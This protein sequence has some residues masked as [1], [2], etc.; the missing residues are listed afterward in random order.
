[1]AKPGIAP[2]ESTVTTACPLDCPDAC[3]VDVTLR[4]GR[5]AKMDG[6]KEN[7]IT[8]GYICA[9]VRRFP[10][11][12]Y[13]DDR[14]LYPAI[15]RGAKGQGQFKRV[16]WD[17]ALDL[18]A[19]K[20]IAAR[21]G[22]GAETILP[23]CYGGSNGFLTQ[24]YA[25]AILFR[26]F[27]T[28]RLLRTV[29]AAPTG[30]ANL[31]LYGKMTSVSY[32]DY[33]DAKMIIV[34]GVNPSVTGIHLMPYLKDAREKGAFIVAIDPRATTVARQADVHLAVRPGTDLA[35]ALAIHR[36][37]FEEGHAAQAFLD[38]H[39]HGAHQLRE[40][41]RPWTF[42]RAAEVSGVDASMLRQIAERYVKTSPALVKCGWGLERNRNGGSA[43]AAILALPA[44]AGKFGVRG[45][46]YTMSNSAAWNIER[47]WAAD[48][49]PP[50]R[51][52]NMNKVGRILTEPEG[53]PVNVLFVY[54]C[55]PV[56]ILPDQRRVIRGLER[57]DLFTVVFDQVLTDTAMYADVA[58]PATTFLEHYDFARGYGPIT[59]QLGKPVIDAVGESRSN[60]DVFMDLARR[61]DLTIDGDPEDDLEAMLT[62]LSHLP[63][64]V[65]DDLRDTWKARAP[66][67]GRPIQFVDVF[68]KTADQKVDLFPEV[69]DKQAPMGLYGFQP[70]PATA[71]YPLAMISPS[72]ERTIS[73]TLGELSRPDVRL[74]MN[75][76]DADARGIEDGDAIVIFNAQG[77]VRVNA[78]VSPLIKRGTVAMPKGVW[79]RNT[80]NG[81]TSNALTPD[82]LADLGGGACFN[83]ARVDVRKTE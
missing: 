42:E 24:D 82:T 64:Q 23:L 61:L 18:I 79:R 27:G 29:C 62:V 65:G 68:P 35:V 73:S 76:D 46:G 60:T 36:Y 2:T 69:L 14:L 10:E 77:E 45:G 38:E 30:A 28:S 3:T 5:I 50:T 7:H 13:G 83:D 6:S 1:M 72:S 74:E 67:G 43:A 12:V 39:T 15:R 66:H 40:K 19:E 31:G 21:D 70:D 48:P 80:A 17:D 58:L 44:V 52:V 59:L 49:E 63:Q 33:P 55:N 54:N 32:E 4:G 71:E 26:R 11:R 8:D 75:P 57:E 47:T 41:A 20:F 16:T 56:A 51:A 25:D 22:A 81:F 53:A 78:R 9:K 34:W 37:L